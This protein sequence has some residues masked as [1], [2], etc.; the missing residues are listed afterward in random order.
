M[1]SI[2]RLKTFLFFRLAKLPMRGRTRCKFVKWGGVI[3]AD[4]E[5][6]I[7]NRVHFD[8][9]Y[10]ENIHIGKHVHITA[11]VTILTHYLDTTLEGI[12]WRSGYVY[13]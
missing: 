9:I 12:H 10:P 2:K 8:S 5:S 3:F 11:G 1:K 13:W 7:G 6:F 4:N